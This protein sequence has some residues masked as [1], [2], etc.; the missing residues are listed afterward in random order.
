M[1]AST[2]ISTVLLLG[3]IGACGGARPAEVAQTTV[4]SGA[5]SAPGA[6]ELS[7]P[8]EGAA[9]GPSL[10]PVLEFAPQTDAL[11]SGEGE[12]LATWAECVNRPNLAHTTVVL[13]GSDEPGAGEGL[14]VARANRIRE[15]LVARGVTP[16][17]VVVGAPGA[18]REGGRLGPASTVT[19]EV[20][21]SDSV[22]FGRR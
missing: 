19:L 1:S 14:F 20:T 2:T 16:E 9:C 21:S 22:R 13:V 7:R 11:A 18:S 10:A 15:G 17:R 8:R 6:V 4:T 12:R 3:L 5:A